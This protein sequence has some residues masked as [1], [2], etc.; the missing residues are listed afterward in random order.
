MLNTIEEALDD[1][2]NGNMVIVVDDEDRENEGDLVIAAECITP[3]A[4]NFMATHARGLICAPISQE[5]ANRLDLHSM[6]SDNTDKKGTNFTISIDYKIDT[7]TGISA[8]DRAKTILALTSESSTASNFG[9]PGHIFPIVAKKGGVLVRAGHTEASVDLARLAGFQEA[10]AICEIIKEDGEMARLAD[11]K[12]FAKKHQLK[13]ISIQDLIAYRHQK[14]KLINREV[15]IPFPTHTYGEFRLIGYSNL[16]DDREHIAL[17]KGNVENAKDVLVRV[18]SEC[19][20]GDVFHSLRC[21]CNAQLNAALKH[22]TDE[23]QGILL[24]MRQEGR[25]IGLLNKL[26]AYKLQDEGYDTVEANQM[27]GFK[28]DLR[29][30]GLGAQILNDLGLTTIKLMTNNPKKIVGIEGYNLKVTERIPLEIKPNEK[31][32]KY[33]KSKKDKMGHLLDL[34]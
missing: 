32:A 34:V 27:L 21:D 33:L 20:T 18:H 10:G 1:L 16:I 4:V 14:E 19:L 7:N 2:K 26:K 9:R 28:G 12:E 23:G 22:I 11:L 17:I 15:E 13:I 30:Y 25:G 6:V 29:E 5:I 3:E 8:K 24:Y 31:N